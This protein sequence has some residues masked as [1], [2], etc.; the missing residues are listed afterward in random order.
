M[1]RGSLQQG[2]VEHGVLQV[3]EPSYARMCCLRTAYLSARVQRELAVLIRVQYVVSVAKELG[4][5]KIGFEY[6][7]E[8]IM[9]VHRCLQTRK[10]L[11]SQS[12][13]WSAIVQGV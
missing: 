4:E 7:C 6:G 5:G 1:R 12:C 11:R 8:V 9:L 3:A 13:M 2:I 10:V